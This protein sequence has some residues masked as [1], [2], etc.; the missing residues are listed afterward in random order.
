MYVDRVPDDRIELRRFDDFWGELP[1]FNY[2][3]W[4]IIPD[5]ANRLAE[6]EAGRADIALEIA[7]GDIDHAAASHDIVLHRR[8]GL[9]VHYLGLNVGIET[10][11]D[12][13]VRQAIAYA[14]DFYTISR[15][16][17]GGTGR[18]GSGPLS[19]S[20]WG[21]HPVAQFGFNPQRARELLA[22]AGMPDGF[23]TTLWYNIEDAQYS[24]AARMIQS[25]LGDVGIVVSIQNFDRAA[26]LELIE[27]GEQQMFL[28]SWHTLTGDADFGLYATQ[29]T[30][31]WGGGNLAFSGT[32]EID[33][34]LRQGRQIGDAVQR[35]EIYRQAQYLIRDH[36]AKIYFQQ[37][38]ELHVTASRVNGFVV[39]P[40]GLHDLSTITLA[41]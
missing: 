25:Q 23:S 2:I 29:S 18:P 33:S 7:P 24:V 3:N 19:D 12:I 37:T 13:R 35:L 38:E 39:H 20:V 31:G 34:L 1:D 11:N 10:F 21:A 17:Y 22:E 15:A 9:G 14:L 5:A 4:R 28:M 26:Y 30:W 40:S 16:A 36:A 41:N 32:A 8:M 27:R 6:V